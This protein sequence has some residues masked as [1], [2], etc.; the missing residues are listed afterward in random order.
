MHESVLVDEISRFVKKKDNAVI[1]DCTLGSGGH[2]KKILDTLGASVTVIGL[3]Q[4]EDAIKRSK[5]RLAGYGDAVLYRN[6][7][8]VLLDTVL[9][10]LAVQGIDACI[11]DIGVSQ[12]QL[13]EPERGFSFLREGPLDMRMDRSQKMSAY[14]VVNSYSED[15]L[16]TI[17]RKY[18]EERYAG[19]IAH[20][21]VSA[22][23]EKPIETTSALAHLVK[24]ASRSRS[25]SRIHPATRTFQA[26]RI[27][28]NKEL[29]YLEEGLDKVLP[30]LNDEGIMC[31][32][33]FHSLEDRIVK[34][35]FRQWAREGQVEV[36]TK[37][38][39]TASEE[40]IARNPHARSAKLRVAKRSLH[41]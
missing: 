35:R 23:R 2:T 34:L 5:E 26:L 12:D 38:P 40:E 8:F 32:I 6:C 25:F 9:S 3:D 27:E 29:D 18:G 28:V 21:I 33:S 11:M 14:D 13:T 1:L 20:M 36:L 19:R 37:K 24:R 17:I 41:E 10:D 7:N 15:S 31:V 22:R 30:F 4:D 39:I 16:R